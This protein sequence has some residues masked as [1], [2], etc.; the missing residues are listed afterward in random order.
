VTESVQIQGSWPGHAVLEPAIDSKWPEPARPEP[1]VEERLLGWPMQETL[2]SDDVGS[3]TSGEQCSV[4]EDACSSSEDFFQGF[5]GAVKSLDSSSDSESEAEAEVNTKVD[6]ASSIDS[7]SDAADDLEVLVRDDGNGCLRNHQLQWM[8]SPYHAKCDECGS[9]ISEKS[10][11]WRCPECYFDVC[12]HCQEMRQQVALP[13]T[14]ASDLVQVQ[15]SWPKPVM[16]EPAAMRLQLLEI[17]LSWQERGAPEPSGISSHQCW[18]EPEVPEPAVEIEV[19]SWTEPEVPE[20]AVELDVV[21]WS[22]HVLPEPAA[23]LEVLSWSEPEMPEPVVK[24]GFGEVEVIKI[25]ES[26]KRRRHRRRAEKA[27][28]FRA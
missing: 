23:E 16:L 19:L 10:L 27:A 8:A 11:C 14:A 3:E 28:G 20:P 1:I 12:T 13:V 6:G 2:E 17:P 22:E 5:P 18:P 4:G 26:S 9:T 7:G 21:C 25:G 15:G 24:L